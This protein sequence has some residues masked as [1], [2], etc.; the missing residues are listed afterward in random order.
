M[1]CY[2]ATCQNTVY[3]LHYSN[4]TQPHPTLHP[5]LMLILF[6]F[7]QYNFPMIFVYLRYHSKKFHQTAKRIHHT[8]KA[9]N[10]KIKV[11]TSSVTASI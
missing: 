7:F 10:P 11:L 3:T 2:N 6:Q 4:L 9:E 5:A 1:S 8:K